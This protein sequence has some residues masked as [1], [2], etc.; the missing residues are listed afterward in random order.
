MKEEMMTLGVLWIVGFKGLLI[1]LT[2]LAFD[3]MTDITIAKLSW[4]IWGVNVKFGQ[5]KD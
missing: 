5:V 2:I 4:L 1:L 3:T